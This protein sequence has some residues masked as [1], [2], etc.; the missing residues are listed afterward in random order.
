MKK[1]LSV[2]ILVTAALMLNQISI[3]DTVTKR[4]SGYISLSSSKSIDVEPNIARVTF[5]VENN[6]DT[7]QKASTANNEVS[8]KVMSALKR[9]TD[10]KS[11]IIKTTNFSVRPVYTYSK[12]GKKNLK[13]Y[14]A[15]NS[16]T[17]Q[18][19]NIRNVSSLIDAAIS[20]GA[21]RTDGL[22]YTYE[23]ENS[24]CNE[25]YPEVMSSLRK[26]AASIAQAAGASV[27]GIKYINASCSTN[28]SFSNRH[29]YLAKSALADGSGEVEET[30]AA[31]VE[32]GKVKVTVHVNVD[33]YVK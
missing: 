24:A 26:Q 16:I 10:D 20:N 25:L 11:D 19:K 27:D 18:T 9:L 31:P 8:N 6:A 7:A 5:A 30:A 13:Y 4:D 23:N 21:N 33:F 1:I 3:A 22:S 32:A 2:F 15:V 17:V 12:D 14:T 29:V 28:T